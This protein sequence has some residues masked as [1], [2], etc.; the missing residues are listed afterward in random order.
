M[1][2]DPNVQV[3]LVSPVSVKHSANCILINFISKIKPQILTAFVYKPDHYLKY[4]V[5]IL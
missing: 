5:I 1:S 3:L 2:N 4:R